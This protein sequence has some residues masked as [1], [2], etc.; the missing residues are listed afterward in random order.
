MSVPRVRATAQP[1]AIHP[2]IDGGHP[3]VLPPMRS[4]PLDALRSRGER[5]LPGHRELLRP[6]RRVSSHAQLPRQRRHPGSR[7]PSRQATHSVEPH[8]ELPA[9]YAAVSKVVRPLTIRRALSP[10][11]TRRCARR[12]FPRRASIA[13]GPCI[14]VFP[15]A[16]LQ[17]FEGCL[18][19]MD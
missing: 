9:G 16:A 19:P 15:G 12:Q 13:R 14:A 8:K 6:A 1:L 18:H 3:P 5:W 11:H 7:P 10:A 4:D 2:S 17:R